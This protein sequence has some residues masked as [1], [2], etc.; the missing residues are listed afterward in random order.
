MEFSHEVVIPNK[1]LPFRIFLFE[2]KDGNYVREKHW[3]RS[4]EI[5]AVFKGDIDFFINSEEH[6]LHPGEFMLVNSNEIHSIQAPHANETIVLQIPLKIFES[7]Y[8]EENYIRFTHNARLQD[9]MIAN[10]VEGIFHTYSAHKPGYELNVQSQFFMLLYVLVTSY[11]ETDVNPDLV[12]CSRKLNKLSTITGYI[13]DNYTKEMSLESLAGVFGYSPAYL[14][15]MFQKYAMTNYKTYLQNIRVEYAYKE[16][17]N[18]EHTIS[19]VALN[20]GF[21]NSKA[22]S[23]AFKKKYGILPSAYRK[24]K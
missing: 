17:M 12:K 4:V 22:F 14:S 2:G 13:A 11:R 10:M 24:M 15:R 23:K 9:P 19:D 5:F 7:Y 3:H 1:D 18:T 16:L 20:N 8:T 21:P 6:S